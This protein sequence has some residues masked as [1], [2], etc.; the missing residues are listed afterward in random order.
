MGIEPTSSAWEDIDML[1]Y[2]VTARPYDN[3]AKL[4]AIYFGFGTITTG[5]DYY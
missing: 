5:I 2:T 4:N 3:A 1:R